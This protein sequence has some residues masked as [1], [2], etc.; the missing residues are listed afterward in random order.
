MAASF[1]RIGMVSHKM[2]FKGRTNLVP[3]DP[4]PVQLLLRIETRMKIGMH[5]RHRADSNRLGE[6]PIY[7]PAKVVR[8]NRIRDRNSRDL[9]ERMNA[10][11]RPT[12]PDNI[13]VT[14]F[15]P[16]D[17]VLENTLN[18]GQ[19]RLYL[20]PVELRAVIS[21]LEP[22]SSHTAF[23]VQVGREPGLVTGR[24]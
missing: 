11:V 23:R 21:N 3:E 8:R 20:P 18:G 9:S 22:K 5:F 4:I 16:A 19:S 2:P 24:P 17:D 14:A 10:R 13:D 15:Y 6:Q 1:R 12:G 7:R